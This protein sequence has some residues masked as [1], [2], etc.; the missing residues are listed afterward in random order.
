VLLPSG[1][2]AQHQS[3]STGSRGLPPTGAPIR[4]SFFYG[5]ASR[6]TVE[7]G[8]YLQTSRIAPGLT[9]NN[10]IVTAYKELK[11]HMTKAQGNKIAEHVTSGPP[12]SYLR[13]TIAIQQH[14]KNRM[15]KEL[16]RYSLQQR[17]L[18]SFCSPVN[19]ILV[20]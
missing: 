11:K 16:L 1:D 14:S 12:K 18:R 9:P 10:D 3:T 7:D 8:S 5:G 17:K 13:P 4:D 19:L 6:Q 15:N 20:S 2:T